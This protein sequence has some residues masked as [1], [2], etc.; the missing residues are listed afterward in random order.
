LLDLQQTHQSLQIRKIKLP[1]DIMRG[2]WRQVA[3][4]HCI[5]GVAGFPQIFIQVRFLF[6]QAE[7]QPFGEYLVV[8][9]A[10]DAVGFPA[11]QHAPKIVVAI[12]ARGRVP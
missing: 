3:V 12:P 9:A 7:S 8:A 4:V 10:Q 2:G 6:G 11:A 5:T 1:F